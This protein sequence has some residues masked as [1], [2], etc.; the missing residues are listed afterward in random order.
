MPCNLW[1][2]LRSLAAWFKNEFQ[3]PQK[4]VIKLFGSLHSH[5]RVR[6][7]SPEEVLEK[8]LFCWPKSHLSVCMSACVVYHLYW[9]KQ[10][11]KLGYFQ[12]CKCMLCNSLACKCPISWNLLCILLCSYKLLSTFT[13]C[14]HP[15]IQIHCTNWLCLCVC[16]CAGCQ[17]L[18][19]W[20]VGGPCCSVQ[21]LT[22]VS[23]NQSTGRY[24]KSQIY[25]MC[26]AML[27]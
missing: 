26:S 25:S 18:A 21:T 16:D 14:I 4:W 27:C 24:L 1:G 20:P 13:Q 19:P 9:K 5:T 17:P 22:T 23:T 12:M 2:L 3:Y 11:N 7:I 15:I 8:Q 6:K 10:T